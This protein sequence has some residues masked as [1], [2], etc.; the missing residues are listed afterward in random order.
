MLTVPL[1]S[2]TSNTAHHLMITLPLLAALQAKLIVFAGWTGSVQVAD[3]SSALVTKVPLAQSHLL[4]L[5]HRLGLAMI[6]DGQLQV[7]I[8]ICCFV[9]NAM[10]IHWTM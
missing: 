2:T 6:T 3:R 9:N 4:D 1:H 10:S 8:H 7:N 5:A